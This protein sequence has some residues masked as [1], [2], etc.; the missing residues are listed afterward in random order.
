MNKEEQKLD[1]E[2]K[3]SKNAEKELRIA[4]VTCSLTDD[5]KIDLVK[6]L[7]EETGWGMMVCRSALRDSNWDIDSAKSWLIKYRKESHILF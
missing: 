4:I 6:R 7:R 2:N 5:E 1:M 3:T